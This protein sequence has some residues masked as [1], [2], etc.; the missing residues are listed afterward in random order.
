VIYKNM[1]EWIIFALIGVL[2]GLSS[3][4][5][6]L[7][8]GV[9]IVP[10]LLIVFAWQGLLGPNLMHMAVAT[11]LM[12][13]IVTSSTSAY[14]HHKHGNI[15]WGLASKI[16]P[17]LVLGGLFGAAL[18]TRLSSHF[19]QQFFAF[20][21][22]FAAVKIWLPKPSSGHQRLLN[23]SVLLSFGSFVGVISSLVGIGGGTLIVPYL[24]MANQS[25]QRAIGTSALC[26]L[27]ISIAAVTGFLFFGQTQETLNMT[28]QSGFIH[29]PAFL[30]I[31]ST[32]SLFAIIGVKLAKKLSEVILKLLFS[33]VLLVGAVYLAVK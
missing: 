14:S 32:S 10:A 5:L 24:I 29:W 7:G 13:I 33:T 8:G 20:Y 23:K 9:I 4:L 6:G 22:L 25:M 28:L 2:S 31:I 27:P 26:G 3:G 19:L 16:A 30:G 15:N 12:T 18:A 1:L 21:L 11:S 17:G